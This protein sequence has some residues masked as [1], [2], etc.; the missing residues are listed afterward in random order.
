MKSSPEEEMKLMG[1]FVD[2]IQNRF[3]VCEMKL[4]FE[5]QLNEH[6]EILTIF[7]FGM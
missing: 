4:S 1:L 7:Y 5:L 6:K 2:G 3:L